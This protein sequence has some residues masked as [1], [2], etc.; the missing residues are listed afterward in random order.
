[1]PIKDS[2]GRRFFMNPIKRVSRAAATITMEEAINR[3]GKEDT[4]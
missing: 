3:R 4:R 1:M 2:L